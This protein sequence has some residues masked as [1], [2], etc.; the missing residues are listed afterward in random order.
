MNISVKYRIWGKQIDG[1]LWSEG[2]GDVVGFIVKSTLFS[3]PVTYAI[4]KT[5]KSDFVECELKD[6]CASKRKE[7]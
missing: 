5:D 1:A 6:V 2:N 3:K 4:V 7:W